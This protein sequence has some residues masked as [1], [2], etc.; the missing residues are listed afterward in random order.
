[1]GQV[2]EKSATLG[3]EQPRSRQESRARRRIPEI[4]HP[5]V[6]TFLVAFAIR[7]LLALILTTAFD[8]S[9]APDDSTYSVM[10]TQ[11]AAGERGSWDAHTHELYRKTFAFLGPVSAIYG[12]VGPIK[13][14]AQMFVALLGAVTAAATTLLAREF[15]TARWSLFAGL[16]V[17]LLPSQALWS[18]LLLKDASVWFTLS[19]LG[20]LVA[21]SSRSTGRR[22]LVLGAAG[23]LLLLMLAHLREH[24]LVVACF[25]LA[26]A[27]LGG[28]AKH[29]VARV[30]GAVLLWVA[31]PWLVGIG[32][33]GLTLI[34]DAGSLEERRLNNAEGARSAF[35]DTETVAPAEPDDIPPELA[36]ADNLEAKAME[37]RSKAA[38]LSVGD[39]VGKDAGDSSASAP[40]KEAKVVEKKRELLAQ[41][42]QLEEEAAQLERKILDSDET[43]PGPSE[44]GPIDP[45]LRHLPKGLS[46]M[47]LQP[48]PWETGGSTTM[49]LARLEA[50]VWYPL[51]LLAVIG[52]WV[53]RQH[54]AALAFPVLAG[55]GILL[56]YALSEGNVGT[57]FRHR[58]EFV[59]VV[60]LLA[61]LGLQ[62][63]SGWRE[64]RGPHRPGL[65]GGKI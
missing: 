64:R 21:V 25:A 48:V 20:L 34:T 30:G 37:L 5:V 45:H 2:A 43:E 35:I 19:L 12:F 42:A 11:V 1:M 15:L 24:T 44:A 62:H 61:A 57:A 52:L 46:A 22:L 4:R 10:A 55:G 8:G 41:A 14:V 59:W 27:S 16:A 60:A 17:A 3:R 40:V 58:G 36:Q 47:L 7:A 65:K 38:E 63:L 50:I 29:R 53:S 13:L 18:S 26:I 49:Q 56:M 51:L 31:V 39:G 32:P 9:L 33:A 54:L 23:A 28:E 6:I